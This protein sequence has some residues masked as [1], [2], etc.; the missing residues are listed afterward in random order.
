L[1]F[2]PAVGGVSLLSRA[3]GALGLP[4]AL[5]GAPFS[6]AAA[7]ALGFAAPFVP[8]GALA[9]FPPPLV[10]GGVARALAAPAV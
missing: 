6:G 2:L 1:G 5:P 7:L 4:A 8:P 3:P 10:P 9:A